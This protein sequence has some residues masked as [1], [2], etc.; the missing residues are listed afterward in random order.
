M[1]IRAQATVE[2]P[3]DEAEARKLALGL[4]DACQDVFE[5]ASSRP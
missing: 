5:A 3:R 2:Q 4:R 1:T